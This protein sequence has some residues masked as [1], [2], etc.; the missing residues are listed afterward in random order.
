[1]LGRSISLR[2]V[3]TLVHLVAVAPQ[4]PSL[5]E[6]HAAAAAN[7]TDPALRFYLGNALAAAGR[8]REA[9]H[10]FQEA[11]RIAGDVPDAA[12]AWLNAGNLYSD[13]FGDKER[14]LA[15]FEHA[16]A[17][18]P[19]NP[20]AEHN[21]GNV[22]MGM[23][24]FEEARAAYARAVAVAPEWGEATVMLRVAKRRLLDWRAWDADMRASVAQL[25]TEL[26]LRVPLSAQPFEA[27]FQT[28]FSPRESLLIVRSRAETIAPTRAGLAVPKRPRSSGSSGAG[29]LAARP[30]LR[31]AVVHSAPWASQIAPHLEAVLRVWLAANAT[32]G[33][34]A[35]SAETDLDLSV[36]STRAIWPPRQPLP[37]A[38]A[39]RLWR[40][41]HARGRLLQPRAGSPRAPT[42]SQLCRGPGRPHVAVLMSALGDD[43]MDAQLFARPGLCAPVQSVWLDWPASTGAW[44]VGQYM[45]DTRALPPPRAAAAAFSEK[46]VLAPHSF[47]PNAHALGS[48]PSAG[49]HDGG[50]QPG[51][52]PA[53]AAAAAAAGAE[54]S[55]SAAPDLPPRPREHSLPAKARHSM[56]FPPGQ[57]RVRVVASRNLAQKADPEIF[58][59]WAGVLRRAGR[60]ALWLYA[61]PLEAAPH[62]RAEMLARGV[63]DDR[64]ASTGKLTRAEHTRALSHASLWLDTPEYN[65]HS[66]ATDVLYAGLPGVALGGEKVATRIYGSMLC[67]LGICEPRV[68]SRRE[69]ED[70]AAHLLGRLA[71]RR[72][73]HER[74]R[75]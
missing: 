50:T 27:A 15:Y 28:P 44:W 48:E 62:Q 14:A 68:H 10:A 31:V 9:L 20:R 6:L 30:R 29:H 11:A 53:A 33:D 45:I 71:G 4:Q 39:H 67:A 58:S 52:V 35:R 24:R 55:A 8:A 73:R 57:G 13:V 60:V 46:L 63:A 70:V 47:Y 25:R 7:P 19:S 40:A 32:H 3:L 75:D 23:D 72:R 74:L 17:L 22:L 12:V 66:T 38:A 49:D 43:D 65:A 21:R 37:D 51:D 41:V 54:A 1:M 16:A 18:Q 69:Y 64:L 36:W 42:F 5:D 26:A 56:G 34:K 61:A 59:V 2:A